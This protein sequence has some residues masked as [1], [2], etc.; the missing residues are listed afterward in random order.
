MS[1]EDY[2]EL[3]DLPMSTCI[4]GNPPA[5]PPPAPVRA[6]RPTSTAAR[7]SPTRTSPTRTAATPAAPARRV[8]RKWTPPE[9]FA[10]VILQILDEAGGQLDQD[11]LFGRLEERVG[12]RLTD[13]D[14]GTTPEGELRW[15][16]AARRARQ[17]LIADGQMTKGRPGV[18]ALT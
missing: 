4:H 13:A 15:R 16:Y 18:W 8:P 5:P 10:P 6:S 3:C 7:T 9:V 17:A 2:C 1:A 12:E 14:R 11:D